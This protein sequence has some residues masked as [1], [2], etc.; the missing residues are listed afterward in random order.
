MSSH[1][2]LTTFISSHHVSGCVFWMFFTS[3]HVI[4][5]QSIHVVCALRKLAL[6]MCHILWAN[7]IEN[8]AYCIPRMSIIQTT[9]VTHTRTHTQ[10]ALH[11]C[12]VPYEQITHPQLSHIAGY[13]ITRAHIRAHRIYPAHAR[14]GKYSRYSMWEH[15]ISVQYVSMYVTE[16][17]Y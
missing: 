5:S 3:S 10:G 2:T 12:K 8:K 15:V 16:N 17:N 14:T 4:S 1:F 7:K 13:L 9:Y 11:G 6:Q